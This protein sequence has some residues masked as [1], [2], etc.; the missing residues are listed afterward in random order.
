ML[1]EYREEITALKTTDAHFVKIFE[2]HNE[3]DEEITEI[4]EGR[5]F[6]D[7]LELAEMKKEKLRLKD[8]AYAMILEYR[9]SQKA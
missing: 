4:E 9:K 3:L 1:H 8:E 6:V 7:D 5:K 2:R